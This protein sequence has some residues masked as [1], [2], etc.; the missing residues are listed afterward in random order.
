MFRNAT[1]D[2]PL[3]PDLWVHKKTLMTVSAG[4]NLGRQADKHQATQQQTVWNDRRRHPLYASRMGTQAYADDGESRAHHSRA[5][6]QINHLVHSHDFR[7]STSVRAST[8]ISKTRL[9][10]DTKRGSQVSPN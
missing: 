10:S 6:D 8:S 3:M 5:N 4:A 1:V 7:A 2:I 9:L